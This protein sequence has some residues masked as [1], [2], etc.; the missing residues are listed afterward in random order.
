MLSI[1]KCMLTIPAIKK[2]YNQNRYDL[3]PCHSLNY[4]DR[5]AVIIEPRDQ[6]ILR[7]TICNIMHY[8]HWPIIV[9]HSEKNSYLLE[10]L[11]IHKKIVI[12]AD[13][14][15]N[16]YNQLLVSQGFWLSLPENVLIFQTD[17]FMLRFG[18]ES[19]MKYDYIGA[20]WSPLNMEIYSISTNIG[21]GGFSFR[22]RDKMI[23]IINEV[24]YENN[25]A[26]D[27]YY[28]QGFQKMGGKLPPMR[29]HKKFSVEQIY[30]KKPLAVHAPWYAMNDEEL[31]R[32]LNMRRAYDWLKCFRVLKT[33]PKT[34]N[35]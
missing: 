9:Y 31:D 26:E 22:K 8:T 1:N 23:Q 13:F 10:G 27:I 24:P 33:I 12:P 3:M 20:P 35:S 4:S 19:F 15:V 17:S 5:A 14:N 25:L 30:N 32:T 7:W 16:D 18:I 28:A 11:P 21:N 2:Y 29:I 34:L 6:S